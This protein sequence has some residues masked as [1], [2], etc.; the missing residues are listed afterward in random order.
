[1]IRANSVDGEGT[2]EGVLGRGGD[3][4]GSKGGVVSRNEM[5][6]VLVCGVGQALQDEDIGVE[7]GET[8][9]GEA[10]KEPR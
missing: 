3:G 1:M 7:R 4:E 9:R 10:G 2:K 5:V 6:D 8:R